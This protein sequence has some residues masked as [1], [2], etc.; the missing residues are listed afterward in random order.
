MYI[1]VYITSDGELKVRNVKPPL[2]NVSEV[3]YS[4]SPNTKMC[5]INLRP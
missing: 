5:L 2:Y 4:C 1:K 3:L